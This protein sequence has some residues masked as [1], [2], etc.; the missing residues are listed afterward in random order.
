MGI[1]LSWT[2]GEREKIGLHFRSFIEPSFRN[3]FEG[4]GEDLGIVVLSPGLDADF[5]HRRNVVSVQG[6]GLGVMSLKRAG[7]NG[8]QSKDFFAETI[9]IG[10]FQELRDGETL[11]RIRESFDQFLAKFVLDV[12][13]H[14][15]FECDV[16]GCGGGGI[17]TGEKDFRKDGDEVGL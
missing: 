12:G 6:H 7:D 9:E 8:V 17:G 3:D 1:L 13:L 14:S 2:D 15:Q 5:S 4:I 16:G 11:V 10:K